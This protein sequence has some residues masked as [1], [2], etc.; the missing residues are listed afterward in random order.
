MYGLSQATEKLE[1]LQG[2]LYYIFLPHK[3]VEILIFYEFPIIAHFASQ[4]CRIV[5]FRKHTVCF[6]AR[7]IYFVQ[8]RIFCKG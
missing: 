6:Q 1:K 2:P 8:K 4:K 7:F 3:S 5:N